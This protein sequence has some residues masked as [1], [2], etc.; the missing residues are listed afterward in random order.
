MRIVILVFESPEEVVKGLDRKE[1]SSL[2]F[3][4]LILFSFQKKMVLKAVSV[5]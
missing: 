1:I 2:D 4:K 5:V 3:A